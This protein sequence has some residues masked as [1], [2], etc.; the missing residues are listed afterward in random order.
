MSIFESIQGLIIGIALDQ[1]W[2]IAIFW[3]SQLISKEIQEKEQ[4]QNFFWFIIKFIEK[5]NKDK[6]Y[7]ASWIPTPL[8]NFDF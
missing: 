2:K 3:K 1:R 5:R 6:R 7:I 8:L 4:I